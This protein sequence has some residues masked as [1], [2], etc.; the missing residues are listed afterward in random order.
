VEKSGQKNIKYTHI[1]NLLEN[2][3]KKGYNI[4]YQRRKERDL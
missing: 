4:N 3:E 2:Q 1:E